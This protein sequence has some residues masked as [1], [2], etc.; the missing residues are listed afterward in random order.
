MKVLA[1]PLGNKMEEEGLGD[2]LSVAGA[3]EERV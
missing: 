2:R 1:Q 3:E